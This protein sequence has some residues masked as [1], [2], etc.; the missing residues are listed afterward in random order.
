[1]SPG[2]CPREQAPFLSA[3]LYRRTKSATDRQPQTTRTRESLREQFALQLGFACRTI[4]QCFS[5]LWPETRVLW[6]GKYDPVFHEISF[7]HAF[8][9]H[10]STFVTS[11]HRN[12]T[13]KTRI[14]CYSRN[15][16]EINLLNDSFIVLNFQR[17]TGDTVVA[18]SI[19]NMASRQG[20][21]EGRKFEE[22]NTWCTRKAAGR[23]ERFQH[24]CLCRNVGSSLRLLFFL[25]CWLLQLIS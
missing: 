10:R 6:I 3:P 23:S 15:V 19:L 13:R 12:R 8:M 16:R 25:H 21:T 2:N 17:S 7:F 14:S 22:V 24:K 4:S 1:M 5:E 9:Q 20:V 18:S 11:I